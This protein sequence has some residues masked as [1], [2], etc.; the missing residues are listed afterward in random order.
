MVLGG[1]PL[2]HDDVLQPPWHGL[3]QVPRVTAF[4]HLQDPELDNIP[5]QL[6]Q[7]SGLGS[8]SR[9]FIQGQTFL[10]G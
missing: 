2:P 3:Y 6:L 5:L 1:I 10:M 4:I 8:L 7:F 9:T